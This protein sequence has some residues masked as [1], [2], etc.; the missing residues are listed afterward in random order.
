LSSSDS[1]WLDRFSPEALFVFSG[2]SQYTGAVIAVSLFD[3][4]GA[5]TVAWLRVIGAA[6]VLMAFTWRQQRGWTRREVYAAMLF[7]T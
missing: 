6:L 4:L 5:G 3:E 7:G 1:N 2:I